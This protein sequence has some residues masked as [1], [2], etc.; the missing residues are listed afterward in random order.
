MTRPPPIAAG[1]PKPIADSPLVISVSRGRE[2]GPRLPRHDLVRPDVRRH[3]RARGRGRAHRLHQLGRVQPAGRVAHVVGGVQRAAGAPLSSAS[4]QRGTVVPVR[5]GARRAR[6][7][8]CRRPRCPPGIPGRCS[9]PC[10]RAAPGTGSGH[11][12]DQLHRVE[13]GRHD[14]VAPKR[15]APRSPGA[16]PCRA[17]PRTTGC[18]RRARPWPSRRPPPAARRA[19]RAR[20]SAGPSPRSAPP[21]P[22]PAAPAAAPP[23]AAQRS[24]SSTRRNQGPRRPGSAAEFSRRPRFRSRFSRTSPW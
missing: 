2:R 16:R 9:A 12:R 1:S 6:P 8:R 7:P 17:C 15:A 20:A 4:D 13:P 14:Q 5:R 24:G 11:G 22:R 10:P 21:P 3:H 18:P 23:A 19:R